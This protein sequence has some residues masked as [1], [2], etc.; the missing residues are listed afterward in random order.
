MS[1]QRRFFTEAAN[2][3]QEWTDAAKGQGEKDIKEERGY[4]GDTESEDLQTFLKRAAADHVRAVL[5]EVGGA[6]V[7][8][9]K[10]LEAVEKPF[11][12]LRV[13]GGGL[14]NGEDFP[15]VLSLSK[16]GFVI[17]NNLQGIYQQLLRN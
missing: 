11:D 5:K 1:E 14:R 13:N 10:R 4:E 17:V 7:E 12:K 9:A 3:I 8:A 2:Y 6:R 16:H 15:F